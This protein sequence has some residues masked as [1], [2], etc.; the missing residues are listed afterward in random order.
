MWFTHAHITTRIIIIIIISVVIP[1]A[2]LELYYFFQQTVQKYPWNTLKGALLTRRRRQHI[3]KVVQIWPGQTVT[4][5]HTNS[6]SHIWT[7]L[8]TCHYLSTMVHGVISP[9]RRRS[10]NM[11][12]SL[13]SVIRGKQQR[14][15][16]SHYC[17]WKEDK[18]GNVRI[19]VKMRGVRVTTVAL[20]KQYYIFRGCASV[21][22]VIHNAMR[23]HRIIL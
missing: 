6:P 13:R 9:N 10:K 22:L 1:C 8:Y 4:C 2:L 16:T 12:R 17:H 3:Y 19:N 18:T 23:M 21:A 11:W 20:V 14:I 7:T 5:L 15:V